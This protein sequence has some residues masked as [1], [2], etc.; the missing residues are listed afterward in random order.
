M[1]RK[2][3]IPKSNVDPFHRYQRDVI[4]ISPGKA[5]TTIINNLETIA[6]QIDRSINEMCNY[7]KKK[8][9]TNVFIKNNETTLK[10]SFTREQLDQLIEEYIEANV[11]CDVCGNPETFIQDKRKICKACGSIM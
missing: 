7:M 3:N 5:N 8:T 2:V 11:L 9:G 10:G 6:L 4:Q 1:S